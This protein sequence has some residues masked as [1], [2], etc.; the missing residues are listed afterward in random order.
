MT[1]MPPTTGHKALIEFARNLTDQVVVI[2]C[3][4]PD[5]PFTQERFWAISRAA[6]SLSGVS[7]QL[8]HEYL[9]QEPEGNEGFWD[10]W[11]GFLHRSGFQPGDY[12]VASEPYGVRLAQEA[13]G[14][15]FPYDIDRSINPAKATRVREDYRAN[16]NF[17]LP[18]F[19]PYLKK[20]ITIFGAESVGKTT[21]SS[22]LSHTLPNAQW[23]FEWARPYLETVGNEVTVDKMLD[24]Y[25]GQTAL[26]MSAQ[27]DG[28]EFSIFDTDLF[29]TIGY[30]EMYSPETVPQSIYSTAFNLRSDLYVVLS[31][32]IPFE[33]DPLRYGGDKRESE[34]QY[35]IDLLNH[36][37]LP[38]VYITEE[39]DR[40][41]AVAQ[42]I[43]SRFKGKELEYQ[44]VGKE[45]VGA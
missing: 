42:A 37:Q 33:P 20:K 3:T 15:Y 7:I 39:D 28:A 22:A 21:T 30:W 41:F 2:L 19:K 12:I 32:D 5:E 26:Q 14:R 40:E 45:Y 16:W 29:S 8:I 24:I 10:M 18:E 11:V 4:Q 38:Y 35:W 25:R 1:A 31:S 44:R 36:F 17:I 43:E 34:D 9:P 13:G 6:G 27:N 23:Y